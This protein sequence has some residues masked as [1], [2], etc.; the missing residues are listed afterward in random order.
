MLGD[1]AG[2][3]YLAHEAMAQALEAVNHMLGGKADEKPLLI[4][5]CV[6]GDLEVAA[7]GLTEEEAVKGGRKVKVSEFPF[8]ANGRSGILGKE[9]GSIIV[10]ADSVTEDVLGFH[11]LGP[12]VTE[13]VSL[14]TLAMQNGIDVRGI[15]KIVFPH[16]TLL[17]AFHDAVLG[18]DDEANHMRVR[19][20]R[21]EN[22]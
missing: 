2:P 11:M 6:Y 18:S 3:P 10:V 17:E 19:S 5:N 12:R 15:K 14:A 16:P 4:P 22:V 8:M 21:L 13:L 7:V 20:E 9:E 1:A